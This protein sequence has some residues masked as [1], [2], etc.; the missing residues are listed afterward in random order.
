MINYASMWECNPYHDEVK[1]VGMV[2]DRQYGLP[3][4]TNGRAKPID[5]IMRWK[6]PEEM[7]E[8]RLIKQQGVADSS[9]GYGTTHRQSTRAQ[10][11]LHEM[12]QVE[13]D[14]IRA[15]PISAEYAAFRAALGLPP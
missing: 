2:Y 1:V 5:L 7:E 12:P 9:G 14:N 8:E 11:E 4:P 15:K 10:S 3:S 6:T 13:E